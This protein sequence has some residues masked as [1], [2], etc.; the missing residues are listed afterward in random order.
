[1]VQ[2][3]KPNYIEYPKYQIKG[4]FEF[5]MQL[6][7]LKKGH[8]IQENYNLEAGHKLEFRKVCCKKFQNN[9]Y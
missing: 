7:K 9:K 6:T 2:T 1:M 4:K 3:E 5:F 8:N